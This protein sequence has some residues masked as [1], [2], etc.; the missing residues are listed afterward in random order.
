M[1]KL[2]KESPCSVLA[3]EFHPFMPQDRPDHPRAAIAWLPLVLMLAALVLRVL[4]QHDVLPDYLGNFSPLVAFAFVGAVV[5]PRSL[6]WWSWAVLLLLIDF[7]STRSNWWHMTNGRPEV[8]LAYVCYALAAWWGARKRGK[9]GVL[10]TMAGTLVCSVIFFLVTNS[11]SWWSDPHYAKD[12]SGW[13]QA[14]TVGVPGPFPST[15]LFFRNSLIA[16]IVGAGVLLAVYNAEAIVRHLR[17]LPW[18]GR[19]TARDAVAA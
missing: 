6:P 19:E 17:T 10:D 3:P 11:L 7:I 5:F 1:Y 4:S 13:V 16:D 12:A 15:L 2:D 9:A 8:L 14:L 18:I